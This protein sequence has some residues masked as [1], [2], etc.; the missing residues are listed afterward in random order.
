MKLIMYLEKLNYSTLLNMQKIGDKKHF[1]KECQK[2][3]EI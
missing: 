2:T 1:F 3:L